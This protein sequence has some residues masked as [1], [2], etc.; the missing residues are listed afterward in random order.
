MITV[1]ITTRIK[2]IFVA[3]FSIVMIYYI[4]SYSIGNGT[5][6]KSEKEIR[7]RIFEAM[8]TSKIVTKFLNNNSFFPN[9]SANSFD[10]IH[11]NGHPFVVETTIDSALQ[12]LA[13][14]FL[15]THR[16]V[17]GSIVVTNAF[18]GE[19]KAMVSY[20]DPDSSIA[21]LRSLNLALTSSFPAA[22]I[23]KYVAM[24]GYMDYFNVDN[25]HTIDLVGRS[26][27]LFRYQ[28]NENSNRW[29]NPTTLKAAFA[30]STNP[31]FGRMGIRLGKDNL[32]SA[33][34][35]FMFNREIPFYF[36]IDTSTL[37]PMQEEFNLAEA[38]SGFNRETLI[39]PLHA[40][41]LYAPVLNRSYIPAPRLLRKITDTLGNV[42]Y[43][44][45]DGIAKMSDGFDPKILSELKDASQK[46]V[47]AGTA[48]RRARR[49]TGRIN[50]KSPEW[51]FGGKTGNITGRIIPGR[52]DWFAG[53][54]Y[55]SELGEYYTFAVVQVHGPWWNQ[56]SAFITSEIFQRYITIREEYHQNLAEE[57]E[58]VAQIQRIQDN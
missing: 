49:L 12:A 52:T 26:T 43:K 57:V 30:S 20:F 56:H 7:S 51:V 5:S 11:V 53:Y 22:S 31:V 34:E 23:F 13:G 29:A 25:N 8:D 19:I 16:P 42:Y 54:L 37:I 1:N 3:F 14:H 38:A 9:P 44:M 21:D 33:A 2:V 18:T 32:R 24:Y 4:S 39:S 28:L 36:P 55:N 40:S 27:T 46:V 58:E 35:K 47:T 50:S 17:Y 6:S 48:R 15:R 45:P 41:L 10:T